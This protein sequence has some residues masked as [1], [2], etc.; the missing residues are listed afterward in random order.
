MTRQPPHNRPRLTH[1]P[2][3]FGLPWLAL[4]ITT[5]CASSVKPQAT[6][7]PEPRPTE[8]APPGDSGSRSPQPTGP[9]ASPEAS[10]NSADSTKNSTDLPTPDSGGGET[11]LLRLQEENRALYRRLHI[12]LPPQRRSELIIELLTDPR[13]DHQ[14]L[15]FELA[16]RDLS[17]SAALS[18]EVGQVGRA[19]IASPASKIRALSA[20]LITRLV[21]PDAMIVITQALST[22]NDPLAAEPMLLGI[23]RWPN[24]EATASVLR[25]IQQD[26]APLFACFSA[27]WSLEQEGLWD[28]QRDHPIILSALRS[29]APRQLRED[30]MKLL[31]LIGS[32]DDQRRLVEFMLSDDPGVVRWAASALV[33]SPRAVE[34]LEQAALQNDV[35][36]QPAA[37][38]LIQ[39]RA[40]PDGLRRLNALPSNDAAMRQVMIL[41]LGAKINR[42]QL[43]E[44]VRLARLDPALTIEVLT[45]LVRNESPHSSRSAKSVLTLAE[46]QL[47]AGRPNRAAE[48]LSSLEGAPVDPSD[49]GRLITL[50]T[51][52]LLLL[53][54]FDDAAGI[55]TEFS[56]WMGAIELASEP[57]LQ[58]RIA[59]DLLARSEA[60]LNDEQRHA[61]RAYLPRDTDTG[62]ELPPPGD[63]S[64]G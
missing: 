34:V 17:A 38:S 48:A 54:R 12:E 26:D 40:T 41:R 16:D 47:D 28:P 58:T 49:Q 14:V 31:A 29:A 39:H 30:G 2:G 5:S 9:E 6:P 60:T 13:L 35:F 24:S 43:G 25:W 55:S 52:A 50:E 57:Q 10:T 18:P 1:A 8:T 21:P 19:L 64:E 37:E 42:D 46:L 32:A 7:I 53:S 59:S 3:V 56:T 44:A 20:R 27:A 36:Y 45:T 4:M 23:A 51:Q 62:T 61:L 15:G 63:E 11:A 22:E 33:E